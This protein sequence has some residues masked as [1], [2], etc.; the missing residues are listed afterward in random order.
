MQFSDKCE[1]KS[2]IWNFFIDGRQTPFTDEPFASWMIVN[3][4][5]RSNRGGTLINLSKKVTQNKP[6]NF[7]CRCVLRYCDP[8]SPDI[9]KG[10]IAEKNSAQDKFIPRYCL[11]LG[12]FPWLVILYF[13]S[14]FKILY[15]HSVDISLFFHV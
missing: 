1:L 7:C 15:F 3:L 10:L 4:L 8:L 11:Y 12:N 9:K 13:Q 6:E 5:V 2:G 14:I